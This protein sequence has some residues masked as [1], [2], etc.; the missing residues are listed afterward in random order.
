MATTLLGIF[1]AIPPEQI[2]P[3]LTIHVTQTDG[4]TFDVTM[5]DRIEFPEDENVLR[6][7]YRPTW[8]HSA[9]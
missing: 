7:R 5:G 2:Q 8:R 6:I 1:A 9:I 3:G 4:S